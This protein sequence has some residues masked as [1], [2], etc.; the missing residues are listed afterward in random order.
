MVGGSGLVENVRYLCGSGF[1]SVSFK[2]TKMNL[3]ANEGN[4]TCYLIFH[5]R[6]HCPLPCHYRHLHR[7]EVGK[8]WG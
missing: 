4:A 8:A 6:V 7:P 2:I 1:V 5:H 3:K